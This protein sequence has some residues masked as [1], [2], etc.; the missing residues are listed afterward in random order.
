MEL[1][2]SNRLKQQFLAN[3]SHE[4]R[5]PLNS[6]V[7]FSALLQQH[8]NAEPNGKYGEWAGRIHRNGQNL[9]LMMQELLDF[10]EFK[11]SLSAWAISF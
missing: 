1:L 3:V 10:A 8:M 7:R 5:T 6:I 9:L 2:E 11:G 4:L